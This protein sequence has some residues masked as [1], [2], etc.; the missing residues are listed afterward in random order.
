MAHRDQRD[1]LETKECKEKMETRATPVVRVSLDSQ[2]RVEMPDLKAHLERLEMTEHLE[3]LVLVEFLDIPALM[4]PRVHLVLMDIL[5]KMAFQEILVSVELLVVL[6]RGDH[7]DKSESLV[8]LDQRVFKVPMG[9]EVPVDLLVPPV[10]RELQDK[11]EVLVLMAPWVH[12]GPLDP[13]DHKEGRAT[14]EIKELQ[15][16]QEIT[17]PLDQMVPMVVW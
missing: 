14:M 13:L 10:T 7:R 9:S 11:L 1:Q 12:L 17:V 8:H 2:E 4:D 15:D 3:L 6:G 5:E 16:F